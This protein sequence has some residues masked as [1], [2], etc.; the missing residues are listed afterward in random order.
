MKKSLS[1]MV[2][3]AIVE[4]LFSGC[5]I[6]HSKVPLLKQDGQIATLPTGEAAMMEIDFYRLFYKSNVVF[7][8]KQFNLLY[9]SD[10]STELQK[11]MLILERLSEYAAKVYGQSQGIPM[12]S[13]TT[14]SA[15][16]NSKQDSVEPLTK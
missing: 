1:L 9:G 11:N 14:P 6:T 16:N 13:A 15:E 4:L 8:G 5:A 2:L 7:E 10:A 12:P 3:M